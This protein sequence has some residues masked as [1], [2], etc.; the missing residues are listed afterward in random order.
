MEWIR[1]LPNYPSAKF[2]QLI[3]SDAARGKRPLNQ[4]LFPSS[5]NSVLQEL[6]TE[7][8]REVRQAFL[9]FHLYKLKDSRIAEV[10]WTHF[11]DH[12]ILVMSVDGGIF[13]QLVLKFMFIVQTP[14][15]KEVFTTKSFEILLF[16]LLCAFHEAVKEEKL[17]VTQWYT[18]GTLTR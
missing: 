2:A 6:G 4:Y 17:M 9:P 11:C 5:A 14:L 13:V 16:S 15:F 18:N 7:Q 12:S 10:F 8:I 3:F 1:G